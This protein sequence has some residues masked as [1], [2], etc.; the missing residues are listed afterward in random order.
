MQNRRQLLI[1][2][3]MASAAAS[4]PRL[5][6]AADPAA[7]PEA[8]KMYKLFDEYLAKGIRQQPEA[9]AYI[10]ID[11]GPLAW[12][13]SLLSDR[14]FAALERGQAE[15][16]RFLADL[17]AIDRTKLSGM[18][19]INYD[20]IEFS[21]A[22]GV[23]GD[24]AFNYGGGGAGSPY[25][26]SQLTGAYQQVPD[27][28][29]NTHGIETK[30]DCDA[31]LD[32][33]ICFGRLMDQETEMAEHDF[34]LGVIPPDF[35]IDKTLI[36]MK[37][38]ADTPADK[39]PLV[40]SLVTRAK[41]KK[42]EGDYSTIATQLYNENVLPALNKQIA[43]FTAARAKAVHDA[44]VG[45]LPKGAEYYALSLKSYTTSTIPPEE[46]H[47]LG[48]SLVNDYGSQI[49]KIMKTQGMKT[50]TVGDRLKAM[51]ADPKFHYP[52]TDEGKEKLLADLNAK[53]QV[54][55]AKLPAWFGALPKS[56]LLIKRVPKATEAGAPGGYYNGGSIDG[57]RP[58]MYYINLRDTSEVPSWTLPTLTYHEGIPG[59]HLQISLANEA[60][61]LPL[62]RKLNGN[63]GYQEGWALYAEQLAV[64]MGMYEKDP[65]GHIGML[66]D[67]MFRAVRLVVDS[68]M[69]AKG[70]SREQAVKYYVDTLGDKEASAITEVERYCVW[71]GQACSYMVGKITWLRVRDK[72]KKALG[73]KFD[74]RTFHDAGLLSGVTPLAV[75][76]HVI[77]DY[78]A[79]NQGSV[80]KKA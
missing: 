30:A 39:S 69:H 34:A 9:A 20:T 57:K 40:Q 73:K 54:I 53:V 75:L 5:A 28:M 31:Y 21:T 78:I 10:G 23:E 3:I 74:I 68:G 51:Y 66:H 65:L 14:S 27:F 2:A 36:Q 60:K 4:A 32:R 72:A 22:V 11:S 33:M 52:N 13:K 19:A 67:A 58:G 63:S 1:A 56:S 25:V 43:L 38:F 35:I 62:I 64:E 59:H 26:I 42:I 29:D 17:H 37:A 16:A 70:W 15:N 24:K 79:A 18:D 61:G 47:Q 71:P 44:G 7:N 41:D 6:L 8:A 80:A 49:D 45:R 48:L 55:S 77:D 12:T 50:G 76:E 46:I